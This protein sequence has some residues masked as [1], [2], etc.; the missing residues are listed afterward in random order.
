[1]KRILSVAIVIC[2]AVTMTCSTIT[3]AEARKAVDYCAK[4]G[5]EAVETDYTNH[6]ILTTSVPCVHG[7]DV[8]DNIKYYADYTKVTCPNCGVYNKDITILY[9]ITVCNGG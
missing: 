3:A 2:L 7:Y 8:R 5:S 1:M 9:T 6:L 4:C